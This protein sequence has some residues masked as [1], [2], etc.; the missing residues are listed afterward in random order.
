MGSYGWNA[1][2]ALLR[3]AYHKAYDLLRVDVNGGVGEVAR[4]PS[5]LHSKR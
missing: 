5:L 2:G 3:H 1:L 4:V